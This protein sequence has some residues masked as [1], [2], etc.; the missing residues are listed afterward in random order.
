MLREIEELCTAR[1]DEYDEIIRKWRSGDTID[2]NEFYYIEPILTQRTVM[3]QINETLRGHESIK[4]ALAETYLKIG[5]VAENQ[6][7][8]QIAARVL[9]I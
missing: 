9:G 2:S 1:V 5:Q 4:R 7:H 3:Y 6:G 8:L